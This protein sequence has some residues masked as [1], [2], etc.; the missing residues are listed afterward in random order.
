M[1]RNSF[2]LT[3]GTLRWPPV[4]GRKWR[5]ATDLRAVHHRD[6]PHGI[7]T[8][9][10]FRV[11]RT[12]VA[13][14]LT[15]VA[16]S[17]GRGGA[18]RFAGRVLDAAREIV[19][20]GGAPAFRASGRVGGQGRRDRLGRPT[21]APVRPPLTPACPWRRRRVRTICTGS[22]DSSRASAWEELPRTLASVG[23][24]ARGSVMRSACGTARPS[25]IGLMA[26]ATFLARAVPA[27]LRPT[28]D[29]AL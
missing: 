7:R 10:P 29:S 1:S 2:D 15:A 8:A 23:Q 4:A 9:T 25:L 11:A 16:R 22:R 28:R 6:S 26:G 27:H 5:G 19:D 24:R 17:V 18:W 21:G 3:T 12:K 13:K 14:E 20:G